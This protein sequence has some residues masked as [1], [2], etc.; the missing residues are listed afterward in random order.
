MRL[1]QSQLSVLCEMVP[2]FPAAL[3]ACNRLH[4]PHF[5]DDS[6]GGHFHVLR[7]R[8]PCAKSPLSGLA[9]TPSSHGWANTLKAMG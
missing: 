5:V 8:D 2:E 9:L 3:S 4:A 1:S 6:G 7:R